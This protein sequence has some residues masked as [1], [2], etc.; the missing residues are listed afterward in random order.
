MSV[1][2]DTLMFGLSHDN[3][4][5]RV[6]TQ[7]RKEAYAEG[8]AAIEKMAQFSGYDLSS[9]GA[10]SAS[11]IDAL[12]KEYQSDEHVVSGAI[13]AQRYGGITD[14]IPE[15]IIN[16][17]VVSF[18]KDK[19]GDDSGYPQAMQ[20]NHFSLKSVAQRCQGAILKHI[21]EGKPFIYHLDGLDPKG[22]QTIAA[23]PIDDSG[24]SVTD[25]EL[26]FLARN[27]DSEVFDVA[28]NS[29]TVKFMLAGSEVESPFAH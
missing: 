2:N 8:T 17:D 3:D 24:S 16:E 11:G 26:N 25:L 5:S 6:E 18:L 22:L 14:R 7:H 12:I 9:G 21:S 27:W 10:L 1:D 23:G 15:N 19:V 28:I 4:A 13:H 29:D 20:D